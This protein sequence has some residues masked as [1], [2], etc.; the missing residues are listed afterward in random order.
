MQ[1]KPRKPEETYG[2]ALEKAQQAFPHLD[3]DQ[4]VGT[5]RRLVDVKAQVDGALE[6]TL[7]L[8]VKFVEIPPSDAA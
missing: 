8:R 6:R 2:P 4:V 1:A 7:A 3:P 5:V